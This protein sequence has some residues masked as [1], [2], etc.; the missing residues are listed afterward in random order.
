MTGEPCPLHAAGPPDD[1]V[2]ARVRRWSEFRRW[3]SPVM[4]SSSCSEEK[5][6]D[7]QDAA[8][9]ISVLWRRA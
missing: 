4:W 8:S 6:L 3:S 7:V 2:Q 1:A 9:V 5:P